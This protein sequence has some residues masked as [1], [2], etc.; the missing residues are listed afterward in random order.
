M[1]SSRWDSLKIDSGLL[2][3]HAVH[4]AKAPN[5]IAGVN[6]NYIALRKQVSERIERKAVVGI[7]EDGHQN[8]S[9]RDVEISVACRQTSPIE[10]DRRRH[11]QFNNRQSL[12]ML[13]RG[14]PQ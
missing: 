13:I 11:R 9:I 8:Q 2:L 14:L 1:C 10:V 3:C 4:R 6:P 12:A 7:I 5:E